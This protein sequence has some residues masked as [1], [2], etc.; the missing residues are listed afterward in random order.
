MPEMQES[1]VESHLHGL[2]EVTHSKRVQR[3]LQGANC[4]ACE[5]AVALRTHHRQHLCS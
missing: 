4:N 3:L 5:H 2:A 1:G